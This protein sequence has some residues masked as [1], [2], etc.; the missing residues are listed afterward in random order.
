MAVLTVRRQLMVG[1]T[2][3][4]ASAVR[5][6]YLTLHANG[7]LQ[8]EEYLQRGPLCR[9]PSHGAMRAAAV[10][11]VTLRQDNKWGACITCWHDGGLCGTLRPSMMTLIMQKKSLQCIMETDSLSASN[12]GSVETEVG[13]TGKTPKSF[14]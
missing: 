9:N 14:P 11:T 1:A 10:I 8:S 5:A 12:C 7:R 3:S 6:K 13:T 4:I 2:K